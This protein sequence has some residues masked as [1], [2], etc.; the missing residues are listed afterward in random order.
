MQEDASF[1]FVLASAPVHEL[2]AL[3]RYTQ[4]YGGVYCAGDASDTFNDIILQNAGEANKWRA[5]WLGK[6]EGVINTVR[7][8]APQK[9]IYVLAIAGGDACDWERKQIR[10]AVLPNHEDVSF[11]QLGDMNDFKFWLAEKFDIVDKHKQICAD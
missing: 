4:A 11:K 3:I 2:P 7:V 5:A 8:T 1:R 10:T 6:L 9:Q